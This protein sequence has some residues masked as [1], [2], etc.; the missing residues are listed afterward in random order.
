MG[1]DRAFLGIHMSN[2]INSVRPLQCALCR[3]SHQSPSLSNTHPPPPP[4]PS[5]SIPMT[6]KSL[7]QTLPFSV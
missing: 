5:V 6:K 7:P 2:A 3:V 1:T 4:R